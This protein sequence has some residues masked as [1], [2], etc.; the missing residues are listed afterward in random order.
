MEGGGGEVE[1]EERARGL[2]VQGVEEVG[3]FFDDVD[4]RCRGLVRERVVALVPVG[5]CLLGEGERAV[6]QHQL[7]E[8]FSFGDGLDA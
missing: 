5:G 6:V 4:N 7:G 8:A 3:A 2:I 1:G